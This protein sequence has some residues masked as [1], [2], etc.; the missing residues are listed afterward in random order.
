MGTRAPTL[1]VVHVIAMLVAAV[2]LASPFGAAEGAALSVDDELVIEVS[3]VVTG[4]Y[5]TV[6]VR[7]FS[8]YDELPPTALVGSDDGTWSGIVS[9]PT[10]E[11][12][13]VV[14]DAIARD[15][16]SVRSETT[17][18]SALG[19]DPAVIAGPPTTPVPG[20]PIDASTWWLIGGM[21][22]AVCALAALAWWTFAGGDD[23]GSADPADGE[24]SQ[25]GADGEPDIPGGG[26]A[27][28]PD[29]N[30]RPDDL[31]PG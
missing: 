27:A 13:S 26:E 12:W 20:R 21:V 16:T 7:P 8:S 28:E 5:E 15:G 29:G 2:T 14:F 31:E 18:L 6:L 30:P 24:G 1:H 17:S 22:L 11:D 23:G 4:T 10:A 9:L 3:V 25:G 19:V